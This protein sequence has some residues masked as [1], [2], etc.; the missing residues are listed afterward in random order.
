MPPPQSL[1]AV[2]ALPRHSVNQ[3]SWSNLDVW[4]SS[5]TS[6]LAATSC[7]AIWTSLPHAV[8]PKAPLQRTCAPVQGDD[9]TE[10]L[11]SGMSSSEPLTSDR[12]VCPVG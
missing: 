12:S 1:E 9:R 4:V 10:I 6:V 11:E 3:P 5:L 2:Q 8:G 7:R